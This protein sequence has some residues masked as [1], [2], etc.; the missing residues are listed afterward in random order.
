MKLLFI[1]RNQL[2]NSE[3]KGVVHQSLSLQEFN[4]VAHRSNQFSRRL[5]VKRGQVC[6][7]LFDPQKV[8]VFEG[9]ARLH[10]AF[11]VSLDGAAFQIKHELQLRWVFQSDR[12]FH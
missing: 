12:V 5:L 8:L 10:L 2:L 6:K 11:H 4:V 7:I 1:F 3:Q 9:S